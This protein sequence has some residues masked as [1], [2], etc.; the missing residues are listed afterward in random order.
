MEYLKVSGHDGFPVILNLSELGP[1]TLHLVLHLHDILKISLSSQVQNL[2]GLRHI[3]HLEQNKTR[4][5][6]TSNSIIMHKLDIQ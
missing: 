3:L 5:M 6:I 4:Y 1:Q 2:N